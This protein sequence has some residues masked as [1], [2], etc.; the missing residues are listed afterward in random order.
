M[1]RAV[2]C[3]IQP[4][5]GAALRAAQLTTT[6]LRSAASQ[7]A[8]A[9]PLKHGTASRTGAGSGSACCCLQAPTEAVDNSIGYNKP[10]S[11]PCCLHVSQHT[12]LVDVW[13]VAF[14]AGV[15]SAP[16]EPARNINHICNDR[17]AV[18]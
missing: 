4:Q 7:C 1:Q 9:I 16:I 13:V 11:F 10:R 3:L 17:A 6:A 5:H 15:A 18:G 14:H 2:M 12:P 8:A